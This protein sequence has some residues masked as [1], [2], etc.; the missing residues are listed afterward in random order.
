[1][2]V[3]DKWGFDKWA[4]TYDK[5]ILDTGRP[6]Q[7]TFRDYQR[8]LEKVVEYADPGGNHYTHVLDIGIGT[9]NLACLFLPYGLE[10]TGIDPSPEMMKICR[11]KHPEIPVVPGDFLDI[12]LPPQSVDLIVSSYAFHHLTAEEKTEAAVEMKRVLKPGGRIVIADLMFRNAAE[13]NKIENE[14]LKVGRNDIVEE[15]QDEYPGYFDELVK[16][17]DRAGFTTDG[18]RLTESVWIIRAIL[19]KNR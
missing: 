10:V 6:D 9:G 5:D 13:R 8:V 1:M 18:E 14:Y 19:P 15:Y 7:F 3:E 2:P 17:F 12:P 11:R 4:E 16:V